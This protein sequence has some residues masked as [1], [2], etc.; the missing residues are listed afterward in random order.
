MALST[1]QTELSQ[2]NRSRTLAAALQQQATSFDP[3][4]HPYQGLA[5]MAQAW[6]AGKMM[7]GAGADETAKTEA[8]RKALADAL[9]PQFTNIPGAR[10]NQPGVAPGRPDEPPSVFNQVETAP[11]LPQQQIDQIMALPPVMRSG[12]VGN[13]LQNQLTPPEPSQPKSA[14]TF[15]K[16]GDN[17]Y[18]TDHASAVPG[19]QGYADLV[20]NP[21]FVR[22]G[23]PTGIERVE[24]GGPGEFGLTDAQYSKQQ[25]AIND[26]V[27][28]MNTFARG[29]ERLLGIMRENPGANTLVAQMANI[30]TRAV[31]EVRTLA[32]TMGVTFERG[33]DAWNPDNYNEVFNAVGLAEASPRIKNGFLAMAIQRAM[34]SGLGTGRAL[35]D[36]DIKNQ[37][38]TLGANQ[39]N[40]DI[41]A[42]IF[43]DSYMNLQD[44][45]Y[46][47]Y[48]PY[49]GELKLP[50]IYQPNYIN[51]VPVNQLEG[52]DQLSQAEQAQLQRDY[53]N[54]Y[55][56]Q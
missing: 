31:T 52:W 23:L 3:V 11:G 29:T 26:Q 20:Q 7:K 12:V 46:S 30:G 22:V 5:K 42:T 24:Q 36:Y 41:V 40:P 14:E 34:G 54:G 10:P 51:I 18:L 39:S 55:R 25:V 38:A 32:N 28:A 16:V 37:L 33:E 19:T 45:T 9:G 48:E 50:D 21:D 44:Y 49:K 2:I 53:P 17:G 4:V 1:N 15:A 35:S 6:L 8:E 43:A 47:K 27:A 13:Y 56:M